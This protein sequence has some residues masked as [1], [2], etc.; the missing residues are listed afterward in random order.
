MEALG[1]SPP[2]SVRAFSGGSGQDFK[3][4]GR[5]VGLHSALCKELEP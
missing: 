2:G 4:R 3:E 1:P 5:Q